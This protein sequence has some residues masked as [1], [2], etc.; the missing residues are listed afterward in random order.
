MQ[1]Y[2][3]LIEVVGN[4]DADMQ[5]NVFHLIDEETITK[6]NQVDLNRYQ[7]HINQFR[8]VNFNWF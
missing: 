6:K 8:W 5:I 4:Q 3:R 1:F 2:F 7:I